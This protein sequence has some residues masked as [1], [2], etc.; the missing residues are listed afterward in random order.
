MRN[1]GLERGDFVEGI[2]EFGEGVGFSEEDI[3]R[4]GLEHFLHRFGCGA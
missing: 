3:V 1:I 4:M 2:A